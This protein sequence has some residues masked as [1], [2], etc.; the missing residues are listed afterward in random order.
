VALPAAWS[1]RRARPS[2]PE[3]GLQTH[4]YAGHRWAQMLVPPTNDTVDALAA[5]TQTV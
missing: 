3:P 5:S 1:E 4:Q 2:K